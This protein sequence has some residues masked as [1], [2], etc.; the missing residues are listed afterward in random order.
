M[1]AGKRSKQQASSRDK[2]KATTQPVGDISELLTYWDRGFD[3]KNGYR[4][5]V[6]E[7][8][9]RENNVL[10]FYILDG[11]GNP[12]R[13]GGDSAFT[14]NLDDGM[15]VWSSLPSTA[16]DVDPESSQRIGY[17]FV[18]DQWL[19]RHKGDVIALGGPKWPKNVSI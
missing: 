2:R 12:Q 3:L 6:V 16:Q 15:E 18:T 1:A 13:K 19:G 14:I 5:L 10:A 7:V 8:I 17:L 9:A 4:G 11:E